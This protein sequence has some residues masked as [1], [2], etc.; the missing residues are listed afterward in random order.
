MVKV[1]KN[2][3]NEKMEKIFSGNL[4]LFQKIEKGKRQKNAKDEKIGGA[5]E[6]RAQPRFIYEYE[7]F[8]AA[9][10]LALFP[11]L[12]PISSRNEEKNTTKN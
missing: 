1:Q 4:Q 5:R 11:I 7:C 2:W 8:L 9:M 12:G 6:S 10:C 3:K